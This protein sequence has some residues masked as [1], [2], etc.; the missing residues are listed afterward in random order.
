MKRNNLLAM[1]LVVV[2][3]V[4]SNL[5]KLPKDLSSIGE[6]LGNLTTDTDTAVVPEL[7]TPTG[8]NLVAANSIKNL[9]QGKPEMAHSCAQ[10]W[11]GIAETISNDNTKKLIK[12]TAQVREANLLSGKLT[13]AGRTP[14]SSEL[15]DAALAGLKQAMGGLPNRQMTEEDRSVIAEYFR[16]I[17][18]GAAQAQ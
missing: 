13:F 8:D 10:L 17:S 4:V 12:T 3:L 16:A 15:V 2:A 18:W 7:P 5:D 6:L 11:W 9:L 1:G 14:P